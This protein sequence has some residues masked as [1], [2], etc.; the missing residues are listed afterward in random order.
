M[1]DTQEFQDL[2]RLRFYRKEYNRFSQ[3]VRV[4][5]ASTFLI[6]VLW[7]ILNFYDEFSSSSS[8]TSSSSNHHDY[9]YDQGIILSMILF[10]TLLFLHVCMVCMQWCMLYVLIMWLNYQC[11]YLDSH[12]RISHSSDNSDVSNRT[13]CLCTFQLSISFA[14][15][16]LTLSGFMSCHV[17]QQ[18]KTQWIPLLNVESMLMI[19]ACMLISY[20]Y[21]QSFR[22]KC[23][24][25]LQQQS[26]HHR[27]QSSLWCQLMG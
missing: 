22:E 7:V 25:H 9:H 23:K 27:N 13:S 14:F 17:I 16:Q 4:V 5:L 10:Y 26:K 1:S 18:L 11:L 20:Q 2:Q 6:Q 19:M 21:E 24:N 3:L 15:A 12:H 8:R